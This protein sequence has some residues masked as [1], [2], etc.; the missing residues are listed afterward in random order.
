MRPIGRCRH[1]LPVVATGTLLL[2][3]C[4]GTAPTG[5]VPSAPAAGAPTRDAAT[6]SAPVVAGRPARV[7]VFAGWDAA[8]AA[9]A[10][11][12]I[13]VTQPPAQGEITFR[14]GQETTIAASASGTCAGRTVTGTGVYYTARAGASG[15]DQFALEA[16]LASGET[17]A[18]AFEVTIVE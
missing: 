16:R 11:P 15:T 17:A 4:G 1:T 12:D 13:T 5:G 14:A 7:F 10:A 9:T 2:A 6:R 8:C 3:A 18:R